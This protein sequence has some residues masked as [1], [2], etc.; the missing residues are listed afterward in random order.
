MTSIKRIGRDSALALL[1]S[2]GLSSA[3]LAQG[4]GAVITYGPA[5]S[6]DV[7]TL[8]GSALIALAILLA[9][10]AVRF[11]REGRAS[12]RFMSM[13]VAASA[14]AVGVGGISLV[15]DTFAGPV[16]IELTNEDG[17][18][19]S[20]PVGLSEVFNA[21]ATQQVLKKIEPSPGCVISDA[22]NGGTAGLTVLNGG[23]NGG[24]S[25]VGNCVVSTSLAPADTCSIFVSCDT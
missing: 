22:G 24:G 16:S 3:A 5:G 25:F 11:M 17:G 10:I 20:V 21:T 13:L 8:G 19:I 4:T 1:V 6:A 15:S 12:T 18:E 9:V 14:L 2:T 7:P 23:L